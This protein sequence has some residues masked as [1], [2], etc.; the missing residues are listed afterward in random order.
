MR[1]E[2]RH[3]TVRP[4]SVAL[5]RASWQGVPPVHPGQEGC[6][7]AGPPAAPVA[8]TTRSNDSIIRY[9]AHLGVWEASHLQGRLVARRLR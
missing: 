6:A 1:G 5:Y 8:R 7:L 9:R 3:F 4:V 2:T